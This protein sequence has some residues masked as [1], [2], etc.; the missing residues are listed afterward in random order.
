MGLRSLSPCPVHTTA[1]MRPRC[2]PHRTVAARAGPGT[3]FDL[4]ENPGLLPPNPP[5]HS[6]CNTEIILNF[7]PISTAS[8]ILKNSRK[9]ASP[10]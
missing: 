7:S 4:R 1:I 6:V 5:D 9:P 8:C 3:A 10:R 2:R